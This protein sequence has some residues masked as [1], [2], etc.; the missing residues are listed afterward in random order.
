MAFRV[1]QQSFW[2]D[3]KTMDLFSCEDRY[4]F[5]YLL[6]NPQCNQLGV[7][8]L[9]VKLAAFQLGYSK[10]Q[11]I[12]LLDRFEN[13]L[14]QIKYN[15]ATQEIAIGN[16]LYH[17]VITGGKPVID[18]VNRDIGTISDT[19]LFSFVVSKLQKKDV[20]NSTVLSVIE[21]LKSKTND[22]DNDN[23]NENEDSYHDSYHD[24]SSTPAKKKKE[25]SQKIPPSIEEV[26][27]Y[28]QERNNGIDPQH[29]IDYYSARG[30]ILGKGKMKDWKAA[31]RTWEKRDKARSTPKGFSYDY[32]C[33]EGTSL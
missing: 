30:W 19:S 20:T 16:Y 29:F 17:S 33:D 18:A 4:F 14:S 13:A 32:D 27:T 2:T 8:K 21:I 10:E 1:V 24:S 3:E 7:Y 9:P 11:V 26:S 28:C 15:P 22:N 31:V 6:T 5:L 25:T 23:E 12:V